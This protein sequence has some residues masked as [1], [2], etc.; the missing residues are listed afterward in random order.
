MR[1]FSDASS[2][3]VEFGPRA[4]ANRNDPTL[5]YQFSGILTHNT[6]QAAPKRN[7]Q[8]SWK[9]SGGKSSGGKSSGGSLG[10]AL[11]GSDLGGLQIP[12]ESE[13]KRSFGGRLSGGSTGGGGSGTKSKSPHNR[14]SSRSSS[15]AYSMLGPGK[16]MLENGTVID[17]ASAYRKLSNANLAFSGG[18]LSSLPQRQSNDDGGRMIKDYMSPDGEQLGSSDEEEPYSSDDEDRGRRK[19]PRSL[20]PH[21]KGDADDDESKPMSKEAGK[22]HSLLAAAEEER[23]YWRDVK[24]SDTDIDQDTKWRQSTRSPDISID[25]SLMSLRSR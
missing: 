12:S 1:S 7:T 8:G 19:A 25:L 14:L 11:R 16:A 9:P 21:A 13:R 10:E 3:P 22:S 17:M 18:T 4:V 15:P 5:D 23:M 24:C 6:G 20:N 2:K